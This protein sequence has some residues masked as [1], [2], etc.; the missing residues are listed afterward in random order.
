R[1][2]VSRA[3]IAA[4][5]VELGEPVLW[6]VDAAAGERGLEEL[7]KDVRAMIEKRGRGTALPVGSSPREAMLLRFVADELARAHPF[8]PEGAF[9]QRLFAFAADVEPLL[10]R[11]LA[12]DADAF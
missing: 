7:A 6:C 10:I 9:A 4:H 5:L 3:E 12:T 8:D 1:Q 2:Q 11:F